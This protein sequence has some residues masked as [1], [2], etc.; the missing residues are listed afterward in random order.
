[1]WNFVSLPKSDVKGQWT[2]KV[3]QVDDSPRYE[4][5]ASW[6]HVDGKSYWEDT[7]PAPLPRREY[8]QRSDYNMTMRSSRHEIVE[9][10]WI[11]SQNNDKI[12]VEEN[13]ENVLV[14]QEVG[15]NVYKK[16]EDSRCK[17]G[18]D[19]W[20]AHSQMWSNVRSKWDAV[21]AK[22]QNLHL[23]DKVD[24]KPLTKYLSADSTDLNKEEI[25]Q[26]IESFIIE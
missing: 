9:E 14:A 13:K 24:N 18:Q 10:G 25:D 12:L 15:Y 3:F 19:Y 1:M 2:Q 23:R 20:K 16:V 21:F 4:G 5:S 22:D 26:I 8:T 17:G 7:T 6:V 11:H